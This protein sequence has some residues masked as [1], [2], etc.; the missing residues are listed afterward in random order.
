[1]ATDPQI[2]AHREWIGWVQPEG[3]VVSPAALC[4]AQAY[5]DRNV[6]TE[7][8]KLQEL[9]E[10]RTVDDHDIEVLPSL[11]RFLEDVLGWRPNDLQSPPDDLCVVLPEYGETLRPTW[12][13]PAPEHR[14]G[15]ASWLVLVQ[16]LTAGTDLDAVAEMDARRWQ[17]S[18]QVRF[19]RL[20]R[21]R[22]VP[23]GLLA[24]G[25]HLRLVYA[26][27]GEVSG[28][29]TFPVAQMAQV[30]GRLMLAAVK[31][32]LSAERVFVLRGTESLA[33]LLAE[34]RKYQNRV[35]AELADQVLAA[36]W[37]LLR[38]FQ[39][40][41]AHQE[42]A[43]LREVLREDPNHIYAGLLTVLMRLVFVLY[44][45]DRGLLPR[46][47]V[48]TRHYS[49]TGLFER[50]REDAGRHHDT[51]DRRYGAWA[52]LLAL[53]RLLHDGG[54]H[55][56]LRLPARRGH[57]FDPDR[58]PFLEGRPWRSARQG[59]ERIDPPLISDG[60]VQHVLDG[61]LVLDGE[62]L[63]YRTLDVE[64]IG[65]VYETMMGFDLLQAT[66][67]TVVV[68]SGRGIPVPVDLDGL[69]LAA[70][71]KRAT[72]L[73]GRTD[74][75][76]QGNALARLGAA[77]TVE[78]AVVALGT[79]VVKRITETIAPVGT[80][81]LQ[82]SEERRRS[83]SHYTPRSLTERIVRKTLE[84]VLKAL[85]QHPTPEQILDLK[86][87]DPAMGSGAFLVEACRQLGDALSAAW[88]AHECVPRIPPDEDELLH[89]RRL[90]AQRCLYGVD[91]NPMAVDL[92]KLSLW[93]ATLARDH[94]FAFVD[95]ALRHGDSLVGLTAAQIAA[96][97]WKP[98]E[99]RPLVRRLIEQRLRT[100]W[101]ARAGI[102]AAGDEEQDEPALRLLLGRADEA[103]EDVRVVGDAVVAAFFG[104]DSARERERRTGDVA[105]IVQAWLSGRG[106]AKALRRWTSELREGSHR[107]APLSWEIEFP[108]VFAREGPGFDAVVGNPPFLGGT[109]ISGTLGNEYFD[110]LKARFPG[111]GSRAD[112]VAYFFRIAFACIRQGG[113]AGLIATNTVGQGDTRA[114]GLGV[115]CTQG[116]TIYAA[117]KRYKWPGAAAVVVSL[118]HIAK[119]G[120][121]KAVI[122]SLRPFELDGK[123]VPLITAYMFHAGTNVDPV[124]LK[125]N[126]GLSFKGVD[127]LGMGF[128]F[129]DTDT[130]GVASTIEEMREILR[131]RPDY[132]TRI[133]PYIGGEELNTS[134]T[135]SFHR[136][137]I[138]LSD[139]TEREGRERYPE[140]L[141]ILERKVL[142]HRLTLRDN[143]HGK[144]LKANWWKFNWPRPEMHK[145]I[146][147]LPRVLVIS[148]VGNAFA[149]TFLPSDRLINEKIVIFPFEQCAVFCALQSRIHEVWARFFSSTLKDD[150]SY[151][152]SYCFETFPLAP[153]FDSAATLETAGRAYYEFRS[154]LMVRN[155]EGLTKTY[156]RFNDPEERSED[157]LCL[158][159]LHA[160]MDR[161]VLDAYG[162]TNIDPRCEFLL[163]YEEDDEETNRKKKPWRYRWPDE[164][165]DEVLARLLDLNQ[166]RAREEQLAATVEGK[167]S[168]R[169]ARPRG[170]RRADN[171]AQGSLLS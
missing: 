8:M 170:R 134:P 161:A 148:R 48:W 39:A 143:Q 117:R 82:P 157:I 135:H 142:P 78:D 95:H 84:P 42:G 118:V 92:A 89:A 167:R 155:N 141:T 53:F 74:Q 132:S 30:S 52:Q 130:S 136:Y 165:R 62:R 41:D 2:E 151:T 122:D 10:T 73:R 18:P 137:A 168:G 65:S 56:D 27:R 22:E 105:P 97:H 67:P 36:L 28:H 113:C 47:P 63:S 109:W 14:N 34:S 32:L 80:L 3:L 43:L 163:D 83:G 29:A 121:D 128:T 33:G 146:A 171:T 4:D 106:D 24:N 162:W 1:M 75:T 38:G 26:P 37:D 81:V 44:A 58:Y 25:T 129:D 35:S 94:D 17:A 70:P 50:L 153:G 101:E 12:A 166:Q 152:P 51:M 164:L 98:D 55:G 59:G 103:V 61:L 133:K 23:I 127:L 9:L 149:F 79:R 6:T 145:A 154:K 138:D 124:A 20:L 57:L 120:D 111:G 156:N 87:C 125:A 115:I 69:L 86:V 126:T 71:D 116:G 169:A 100:A 90:V 110:W 119:T 54:G 91:K 45:E 21:E 99:E 19:E 72:W 150:L 96:V 159:E 31:L 64:Q 40:A 139:L 88:H 76:L 5:V 7:Q 85:G 66:G 13:V 147:G 11:R 16:D 102:L 114:T 60:V 15:Q 77:K 112:L 131:L 160:A 158:R 123:L 46:D 140:L 107:I 68:R 144:R 104:G 93:L 108:E 49:V